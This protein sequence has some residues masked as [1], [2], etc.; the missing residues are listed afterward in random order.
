MCSLLFVMQFSLHPKNN[1][2]TF[3]QST[4]M[5]TKRNL[6]EKGKQK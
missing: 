2:M 3:S 4:Y 6:T 5:A 1:L